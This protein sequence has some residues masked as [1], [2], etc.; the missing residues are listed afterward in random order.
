MYHN[1]PAINKLSNFTLD[2]C[3]FDHTLFNWP[4]Y[5]AVVELGNLPD[6]SEPAEL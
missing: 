4:I 5:R 6:I 3:F 1:A 2:F